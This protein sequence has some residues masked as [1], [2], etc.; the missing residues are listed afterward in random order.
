[1]YVIINT[2]IMQVATE[3][4]FLKAKNA[5]QS[6]TGVVVNFLF[7]GTLHIVLQV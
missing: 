1:M 6:Y 3:Q 2:C 4:Y 7:E 5:L